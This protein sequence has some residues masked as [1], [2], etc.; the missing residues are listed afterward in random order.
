[1]AAF[2]HVRA[3]V[4]LTKDTAIPA[5]ACMNV[6]HFNCG[7]GSTEVAVEVGILAKLDAFYSDIQAWYSP[8]LTGV[9]TLKLFDLEDAEPRIPF[10]TATF[11]LVPGG[12]VGLPS[13]VAIAL[14]YKAADVSGQPPARRRGRIFLGPFDPIAGQNISGEWRVA[15]AVRDDIAQAG[16]TLMVPFVSGVGAEGRWSVFSPTTLAGGATLAD[17]FHD[18]ASG[19]VDNAFDTIRSRGELASARSVF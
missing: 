18:V 14:S 3:Q 4:T 12:V 17:S 11:N 16:G 15:T 5:D 10:N 2:Q 6:W 7:P 8:T 19:H 13:E 1:M 9:A